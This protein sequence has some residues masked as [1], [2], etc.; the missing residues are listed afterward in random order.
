M[1]EIH[2]IHKIE[3]LL[4]Q[5]DYL[6]KNYIE[7]ILNMIDYS[8]KKNILPLKIYAL[9]SFYKGYIK[10]NDIYILENGIKYV[11]PYKEEILNFNI[12][13]LDE[14]DNTY[15]SL[16]K[17]N[18]SENDIFNIIIEIKNNLK[19][20]NENDINTIKQYVELIISILEKI[21]ILYQY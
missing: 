2:N 13:N 9:T 8:L 20:L 4:D 16:K 1:E 19:K 15:E 17:F 5:F 10:N 7:I 21:K 11:L 18:T 6:K 14:L 3:A 12:N